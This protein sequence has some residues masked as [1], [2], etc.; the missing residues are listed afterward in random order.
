MISFVG[1][2]S[3]LSP[4]LKA[5]S[6]AIASQLSPLIAPLAE[7]HDEEHVT[8]VVKPQTSQGLKSTIPRRLLQLSSNVAG[9]NQVRYAHTD[10]NFPDFSAYRRESVQNPNARSS[11]SSETRRAFTYVMV[12]GSALGGM[13]A[14]K[15]VVY[16]LV[17]SMSASADVLALAKIEVK[18]DAIP[19]GK[20]L[21]VKWRGKP[22]FIRHRTPEEID[23]EAKVSL[24]Q[25]RD[26]QHDHE[27]TQ[28]PKWLVVLGVCTHLG[29]IPIAHAGD[30]GGYYC[31]CHGSHYDVSGR[32]RKGPAPLNLE[33]PDY[34]FHDDNTVVVG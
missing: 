13:Y 30:Y 8:E 33:V 7:S 20:N 25:L 14:A 26:P 1:R 31:P 6:S 15:S 27:R 21:T 34:H 12:A 3:S 29:C 18:L 2:S 23:T 9:A 17:S 5:V 28:H 32:I 10:I 24:G 16:G 11:D 22:L 4:H 19:V